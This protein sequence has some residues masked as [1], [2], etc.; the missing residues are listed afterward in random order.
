[1]WGGG[2]EAGRAYACP[3]VALEQR[4]ARARTRC[5]CR[6][7]GNTHD[8]RVM[9]NAWEQQDG[10]FGEDGAAS[11][12]QQEQQERDN[13]AADV[14]VLVCMASGCA[15]S[16]ARRCVRAFRACGLTRWPRVRRRPSSGRGSSK[17]SC[18]LCALASGW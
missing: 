17:D 15:G 9:S 18:R 13:V 8:M 6:C 7:L 10:L 3:R 14:Q 1:V 12:E 4:R 2:R 16:I 5:E 11:Q